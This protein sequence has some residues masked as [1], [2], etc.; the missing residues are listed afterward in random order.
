M[1]RCESLE[2]G[3][4]G[5]VLVSEL[6]LT[7]P[8]GSF[9]AVLGTNG[10]GKSLTLHTLAGLRPA[11]SGMVRIDGRAVDEWT[12]RELALRL[13][14][15]PQASEDPFPSTV[16]EAVL[17]GRHPHLGFWEWEG[18]GD[19]DIA[20]A[21]LAA[22]DLSGFED[23]AVESLSGGERRRLAIAG[24]LAQDPS[25]CLLDEPTNH[26]DP[27][28]QIDA[29]ALF[30]SRVDRGGTV[31]ATLHDATLAARYADQVLLLFG[32]GSWIYGDAR[33]ALRTDH[34]ARLY[35]TPVH[36]LAFEGR[37]IFVT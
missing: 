22:V 3:I 15:L 35:R 14:L 8:R 20:K 28:H 25:I 13:S 9:V 6:D 21:A 1:L 34:L 16:L 4:P 11:S 17:V 12:R 19:L 5:R 29:L 27:N 10:A 23:R 37:R 32:D 26:L 18:E 7:V 30:R 24:V 2:V 36:E 31:I 33:E